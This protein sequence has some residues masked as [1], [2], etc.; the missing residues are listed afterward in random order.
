IQEL[1]NTWNLLGTTFHEAED[2]DRA[3]SAYRAAIEVLDRC[4]RK[5]P[6]HL[7]SQIERLGALMNLATLERHRGKPQ[8]AEAIF[9]DVIARADRLHQLHPEEPSL[10]MTSAAASNNLSIL[11]QRAGKLALAEEHLSHS[12][13]LKEGLL[14]DQPQNKRYRYLLAASYVNSGDLQ[15]ALGHGSVAA[16]WYVR[17][18][19]LIH[20]L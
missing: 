2:R 18:L 3:F 17:A 10:R 9:L 15:A 20:N 13:E 19:A 14:R 11:Y 1:G 12:R 6:G 4:L 8:E 7:K 5:D 16:D